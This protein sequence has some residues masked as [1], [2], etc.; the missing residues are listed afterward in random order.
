MALLN[1][2]T[3]NQLARYIRQKREMMWRTAVLTLLW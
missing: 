1:I 2:T 3:L